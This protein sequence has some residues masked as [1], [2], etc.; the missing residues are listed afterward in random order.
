MKSYK[1]FAITLFIPNAI[2]SDFAGHC[3]PNRHR[4]YRTFNLKSQNA[5]VG[6]Y[7]TITECVNDTNIYLQWPNETHKSLSRIHC[8][9]LQCNKNTL[10]AIH[11]N[12]RCVS[13]IWVNCRKIYNTQTWYS[14]N[15]DEQ[16]HKIRATMLY[17]LQN[18]ILRTNWVKN[19]VV[20][21]LSRI[22]LQ[23]RRI[24]SKAKWIRQTFL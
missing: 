4:T 1:F 11:I 7:L 16:S 3:P 17:T 12:S 21:G 13:H 2:S 14:Q 24:K 22:F 19:C 10:A 9:K 15:N 18:L 8:L 23:C 5:S 6:I 20:S